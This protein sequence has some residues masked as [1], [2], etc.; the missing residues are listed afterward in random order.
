MACLVVVKTAQA[1]VLL[2]LVEVLGT[3]LEP[4]Q[5]KH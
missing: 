5:V 4:C 3:L 2:S 1:V